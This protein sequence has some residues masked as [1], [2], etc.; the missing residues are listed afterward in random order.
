MSQYNPIAS[1]NG[2]A[3]KCPTSFE[4]ELEDVSSSEAGRTEDVDMHKNRIGQ[5]VA[6][7]LSWKALTTSELHDILTA[8]NPEYLTIIYKDPLYG[9]SNDS[10][11]R[12]AVFYVGNRVAPMYNNA[13]D[14]WESVSFKIIEKSGKK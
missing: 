9:D 12:T 1:V 10:Y 6:V 2:I 5:V 8:F 14:I 4:W 11:K 7:S 3:I 13:L